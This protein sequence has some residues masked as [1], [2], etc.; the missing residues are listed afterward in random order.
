MKVW[1]NSE[2]TVPKCEIN[3]FMSN[4]FLL[5]GAHSLKSMSGR[6]TNIFSP[7]LYTVFVNSSKRKI[8]QRKKKM[9][10]LGSGAVAT[11][12]LPNKMM[13]EGPRKLP[14]TKKGKWHQVRSPFPGQQA[15]TVQSYFLA[16][17]SLMDAHQ[18]HVLINAPEF[19]TES[20]ALTAQTQ[21]QQ[22]L[23]KWTSPD[24][25]ELWAVINRQSYVGGGLRRFEADE[26]DP[27]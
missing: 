24:I 11:K 14:N 13:E 16:S 27:E 18:H 9:H 21:I 2:S 12:T 10:I 19:P 15:K 17:V 25:A 6:N 7:N 8:F 3:N 4:V 5:M 26:C 20:F 23:D 22:P 1:S